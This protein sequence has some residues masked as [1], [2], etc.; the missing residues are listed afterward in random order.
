MIDTGSIHCNVRLGKKR[1]E[2]FDA[3]FQAILSEW[4]DAYT[5][6]LEQKL[7]DVV[8][9]ETLLHQHGMVDLERVVELGLEKAE[10]LREILE[11]NGLGVRQSFV[12]EGGDV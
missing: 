6:A 5:D 7:S 3:L 9:V 11:A 8:E 1:S 2:V 10:K 12:K 4:G